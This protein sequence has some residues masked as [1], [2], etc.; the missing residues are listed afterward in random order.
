MKKDNFIGKISFFNYI[1]KHL[2]VYII[3]CMFL[4]FSII[5]LNNYYFSKSQSNKENDFIKMVNH[6]LT[7]EGKE[8]T[9]EYIAHYS[10]LNNVS[11]LFAAD[12][13]VLF[14]TEDIPQYY[15]K[16][17]FVYD[18]VSIGY[19]TV[20]FSDNIDYL[21]NQVFI[22]YT[23]F[24]IILS[25]AI[26]LFLNFKMSKRE[27]KIILKDLEKLNNEFNSKSFN[28]SYQEVENIAV[29]LNKLIKQYNKSEFNKLNYSHEIKTALTI[30][31]NIIENVDRN[32]TELN[33]KITNEI[34]EEIYD[35]NKYVE[36]IYHLKIEKV[37]SL[38]SL[39]KES[40]DKYKTIMNTKNLELTYDIDEDITL[41]F[42]KDDF[43]SICSNLLSNAF[44]YSKNNG[45]VHVKLYKN[46]NEIL[47]KVEDNGIGIEK[48]S[49]EKI[50]SDL[51]R[52]EKAIEMYKVGTGHG[53][54]IIK[55]ILEENGHTIDVNSNEASTTFTITF[56]SS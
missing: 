12:D 41:E 17:D 39:L 8:V 33:K 48:S 49:I 14:V 7:N 29:K 22:F 32:K 45:Y 47:L 13:E 42:S 18:D 52:S 40:I 3:M 27:I 9:L 44:F 54:F 26:L 56:I 16:Y 37:I 36:K 6:L 43:E 55:S 10:S 23:N 51:Y 19:L 35:I 24:L 11:L 5:A 34:K 38:S 31:L 1:K 4:N 20:D 46:E 2:V 50:F 28:Y 53:L 15:K 21:L 30:I 25:L